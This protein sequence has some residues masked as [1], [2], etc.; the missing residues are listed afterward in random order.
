VLVNHLL[1]GFFL[2]DADHLIDRLAVFKPNEAGYATDTVL[3]GQS[4]VFVGVNF[5]HFDFVGVFAG[6]FVNNGA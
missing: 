6:N 1:D 4:D 2:V 5:N 3:L